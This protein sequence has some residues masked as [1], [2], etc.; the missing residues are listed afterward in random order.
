MKRKMKAIRFLTLLFFCIQLTITAYAEETE[1][2]F[3]TETELKNQAVTESQLEG[4]SDTGL[5]NQTDT[6]TETEPEA[7]PEPKPEA[8]TETHYGWYLKDNDWYYYSPE[9]G[10][11][12]AGWQLIKGTWYYLDAANPQ[13]P[14][15]MLSNQSRRIDNAT[16]FFAESGAMQ[17]GWVL[18]PEG[19]Y[20][21]DSS[22]AMQ[23]G[24][25]LLGNTWY[26]LDSGNQAYPG[27]MVSDFRKSINGQTYFFA[28]SGAMRYGWVQS[29]EGWYFAGTSG[30]MQTGWVLQGNT[31]YYLDADNQSYPG[32]MISSSKRAINGQTYFFTN[33]GSMQTGWVSY[34]EGWYYANPDGAMKTGWIQL[35]RTWYYLDGNNQTYPGLMVANCQKQIGGLTYYF[36]SDGSMRTGWYKENSA[37]YYYD[38]TSGQI[39]TGW[40]FVGGYWYYLDNSGKMATGWLK[41]NGYWYYLSPSGAMLTGTQIIDGTK[42][43]LDKDSGAWAEIDLARI[44]RNAKL[45]LGRTL[46]VWGGGWNTADNAAGETALHDGVWPEWE[47]YFNANKNGYS[48]LP[49]QASWKKGNRQWRFKGL[50]CSGYLGWLIYNSVSGGRNSSGYV[51]NSVSFASSLEN[52]GFGNTVSCSPSSTFRPGDIVSIPSGHCFLVLGQCSDGSVLLLH[53]TPNGGV[54]V[55]GTVTGSGSSVASRLAQQYMQQYY[56]GW[57]R[58]F[59]NENRQKVNAKYFLTGAKFSWQPNGSVSDSIGIRSKTGEQVLE[60]LK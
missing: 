6:D 34:P 30:A 23:T 35:G 12:L 25:Q 2:E 52:Y 13:K 55:S 59:G 9:S 39:A 4:S 37:W 10:T 5:R 40:K 58:S 7:P 43:Y 51:V 1:Q 46:Y 47:T 17:T 50:D 33:S 11:K 60:Y 24:W 19:W 57:W 53:S 44:I 54:Q 26:Y 21:A 41:L 42:Y 29:S 48:Y 36:N 8:E 56:P 49:G 31:W 20:F 38:D 3:E 28:E 45:P 18:R 32:L 14:G 15:V 16:Y 27:L 22:G